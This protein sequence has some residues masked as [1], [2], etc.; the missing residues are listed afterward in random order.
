MIH[1]Q[2]LT[3]RV[4]H[5]LVFARARRDFATVVQASPALARFDVCK[6]IELYISFIIHIN[7]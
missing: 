4:V 6:T 2:R 5:G 1:F 3:E 7:E